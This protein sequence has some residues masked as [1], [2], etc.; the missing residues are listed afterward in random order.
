MFDSF[1]IASLKP[2]NEPFPA[3]KTL[4]PNIKCSSCGF[5]HCCVSENVT[6]N[7]GS[8]WM[9]FKVEDKQQFLEFDFRAAIMLKEISLQGSGKKR[10]AFV[11][12]FSLMSS[13]GGIRWT[14][15]IY[16]GKKQVGIRSIF[17]K[18]ILA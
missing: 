13:N 1:L 9:A 8:Y 5:H 6:I 15:Q 4:H 2:L 14:T 16:R 3:I 17:Y 18:N 12:S 7:S 10:D 11:K